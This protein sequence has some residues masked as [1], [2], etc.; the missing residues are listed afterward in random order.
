[1]LPVHFLTDK[2]PLRGEHAVAALITVEDGRYLMQ[3]R[4]DIPRIF[5]PGHWGCFGGAV[6]P[7]ESGLIALRREL[8]EELEMQIQ[9]AMLAKG[10]AIGRAFPP[11]TT[12][13]RVSIGT[14]AEMAKFRKVLTEVLAS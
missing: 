5:Y 10:V 7:G 12:M 4:D 13:I 1:M 2:H 6:G 14:D 11:L 8:E 9:A 3:L